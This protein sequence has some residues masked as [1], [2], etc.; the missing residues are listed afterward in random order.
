MSA[1][2]ITLVVPARREAL[3]VLRTIAGNA[4]RL[5]GLGYDRVEEARLAVNE[6]AAVLVADG[7][8][9]S[10]R[11]E[12]SSESARL[13]VELVAEPGPAHWPP[14]GW[15]ESLE[16]AVLSSVTDWFELGVGD[17]TRITMLLGQPVN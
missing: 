8:S 16:H 14:P 15:D 12:L 10:L 7:Q 11:C 9:S 3:S 6:A 5:S 2:V 1:D 13:R 4:A 17:G